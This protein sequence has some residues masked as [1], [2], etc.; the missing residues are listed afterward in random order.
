MSS[1]PS[2]KALQADPTNALLQHMPVRRLEAE[3]I[4]D[5]LLAISGKLDRSMYGA[6]PPSRSMYAENE[7]AEDSVYGDN[8]RGVYQEIR[9]NRRDP[10]LEVFDQPTPST[11]RGKRDVTNVPA[12]ALALM[13][14][15]FVLG[16]ARE[17]GRRL[18]GGEGHSVESRVNY[19]FA[20]TLGRP[21]TRAQRESM[22]AFV[23][24]LAE[25]EGANSHDVLGNPDV[26]SRLAHT[27]FNFKEF[28][29]VR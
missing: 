18:A 11:T 17:W 24:G 4:R 13:N 7:S 12:Q 27:L 8:R 19:M 5:S 22:A 14:S 26:W 2:A 21:P 20:K 6:E 9:R 28:L 23:A 15:P 10:F 3:A 1:V 25:E 16:A 29:Y